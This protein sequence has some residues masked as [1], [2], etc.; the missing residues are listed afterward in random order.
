MNHNFNQSKN[1]FAWLTIKL[2]TQFRDLIY[3]FKKF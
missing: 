1:S 3:I 2:S